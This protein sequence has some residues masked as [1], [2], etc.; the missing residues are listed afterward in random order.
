MATITYISW[1]IQNLGATSPRF[2]GNYTPL[3]NFIAAV[4]RKANAD[5]LALMELRPEGPLRLVSLR[6][7]L[8]NAFIRTGLTW[9]SDWI[10]GAIK[11]TDNSGGNQNVTTS[12]Q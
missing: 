8:N 9:Y 2:R 4:A 10:K 11:S 6:S 1:N 7:A 12:A 3:F 5:V